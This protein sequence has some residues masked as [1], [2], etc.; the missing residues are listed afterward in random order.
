LKCWLGLRGD[1]GSVKKYRFKAKIEASDGG[2]AFVLFPFDT[3]V[4]CGTKGKVAVRATVGG[5]AYTGSL[6]RYGR[7]QHMLA[8]AKAIRQEIGKGPGDVIEV[9]VWK[10]EGQREL[11]MPASLEKMLKKEGLMTFF[12]GLSFTNRKE[13][14]RWVSE[15]KKDETR[16]RRL[17]KAVEMLRKGVKTPE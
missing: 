14:C 1:G 3:E 7:P 2:G 8:V 9:E 4:E 11:E 16:M 6:M 12:E 5:V 13:C 17:E 10:D 15:A